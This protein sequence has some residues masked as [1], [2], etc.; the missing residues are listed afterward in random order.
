MSQAADAALLVVILSSRSL[1]AVLQTVKFQT[2]FGLQRLNRMDLRPHWK[3]LPASSRSRGRLQME[4]RRGGLEGYLGKTEGL[5]EVFFCLSCFQVALPSPWSDGHQGRRRCDW[6]RAHLSNFGKRCGPVN[7]RYGPLSQ[8]PSKSLHGPFGAHAMCYL[9]FNQSR[10]KF[11]CP[12][13]DL[14][15]SHRSRPLE[16]HSSLKATQ[17]QVAL[18]A[19]VA[20]TLSSRS[21]H[22][23]LWTLEF[24]PQRLNQMDL[25]SATVAIP[26]G[27]KLPASLACGRLQMELHLRGLKGY[28]GKTHPVADV[29]F[30][31]VASK[32]RYQSLKKRIATKD[33]AH[34]IGV[35]PVCPTSASGG[36]L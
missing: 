14:Q 27:M 32:L 21:L 3:K 10:S 34:A 5:A 26:H 16:E 35:G 18:T 6:C 23:V 25:R 31:L 4:L 29:L 22:L 19:C 17:S 7:T 20:L 30:C 8:K 12:F 13:C 2:A 24:Q 1:A 11:Y 33:V 9:V 15:D 36:V 28:L